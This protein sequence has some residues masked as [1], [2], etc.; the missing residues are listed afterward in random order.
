[1]ELVDLILLR[2]VSVNGMVS[3]WMKM[4]SKVW[5]KY[6]CERIQGGRQTIMEE[7]VQ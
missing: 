3:L 4:D 2:D 6:I 1:M 5:N 7:W